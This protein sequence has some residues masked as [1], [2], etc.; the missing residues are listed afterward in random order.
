MEKDKIIANF[1]KLFSAFDRIINKIVDKIQLIDPKGS[2]IKKRVV[3]AVIL[4]PLAIYAILSS[5]NLFLILA[6]TIAILMTEEWL[7]LTKS[8]DD[9]NK[10][11]LIGLFYI[12]IPIFSVIKIRIYDEQILFWMFAVIWTTDIFAFF[13]GK[14]LGG[15]KL[16]P[17]ISPNKTWSGLFGGVIA[18][19][20]L[21][22]VS[23]LMFN[24]GIIFFVLIS[25]LLA[26]IEQVS[27]LVESKVKRIFGVKDSG[28]IIPGHGGILDRLDGMMLV[29]PFVLLLITLFP[30]RF[31]F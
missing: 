17:T 2:D 11:R 12:L 20:M 16:A 22:L 1:K 26:I 5:L 18:S 3:S 23:S 29:A 6:I 15:A 7:N 25:G 14:K 28:S 4:V 19:M 30:S 24:G 9:K 21:G 13:A 10:W 8:A 27:D 31:G